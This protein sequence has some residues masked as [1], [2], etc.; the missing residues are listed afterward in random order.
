MAACEGES[1][2]MTG[3]WRS[4]L[5]G[6][7][8]IGAT[9]LAAQTAAPAASAPA[10]VD[11]ARRSAAAAV[12][13]QLWPLG[14]YRR[15]MGGAMTNMVDGL[16]DQM[17][18]MKPSDVVPDAKGK[19]TDPAT[20][21]TM[22]AQVEADDPYFRERMRRSSK[23]MFDAMLPLLDKMEP[24]LR[25]SMTTIYARKFSVEE[26]G[27]MRSFF[28]TPAGQAYAREWMLSFMDP[29]IMKGMQSFVPEMM[30]EMPEIM[31]KVEAATADLPPPPKKGDRK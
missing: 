14:T 12:I 9:P 27:A 17:Y 3:M 4:A 21:K 1:G 20:E 15:L 23:A 29:E 25:E 6:G 2:G 28:A 22:G 8:L 18:A 30:K 7:L 24:R 19:K 31:K 10:P 11:P 5:L 16:M 26:L 13:D